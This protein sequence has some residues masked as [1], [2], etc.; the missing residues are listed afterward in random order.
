MLYLTRK[1]SQAIRLWPT[2]SDGPVIL[3]RVMRIEDNTVML[4][5]EAPQDIHIL[6]E[7]LARDDQ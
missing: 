2:G 4:G 1:A 7:E 5:I 6:R 3:I